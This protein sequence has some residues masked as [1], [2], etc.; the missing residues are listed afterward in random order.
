MTAPNKFP[1]CKRCQGPKPSGYG[2]SYCDACK[3]ITLKENRDKYRATQKAK[4]N[5]RDRFLWTTYRMTVAE[6]DALLEKQGN[7]CAICL[8]PSKRYHLDHDHDCCPQVRCCGKCI[9]SILCSGC[10][11][12]IGMFKEDPASLVLA[13]EYL[14]KWRKL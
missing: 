4:D 11:Q 2:R 6:Y 8:K 3:V 7:V 1:K 12:G 13:A 9:R 5:Y 10:N 14:L